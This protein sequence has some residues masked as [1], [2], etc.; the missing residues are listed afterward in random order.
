MT[1]PRPGRVPR[2]LRRAIAAVVV[3]LLLPQCGAGRPSPP[4]HALPKPS[5]NGHVRATTPRPPLSAPR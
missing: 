4:S 3:L 2:S 1:L 5:E